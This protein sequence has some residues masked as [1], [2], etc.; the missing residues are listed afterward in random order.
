MA[1]E[2]RALKVEQRE[3][4]LRLS[5]LYRVRVELTEV[6]KLLDELKARPAPR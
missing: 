2:V 4:N 6:R 5:E 1:D 3:A